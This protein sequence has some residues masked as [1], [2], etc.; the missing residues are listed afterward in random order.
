MK[1]YNDILEEQFNLQYYLNMSVKDYDENDVG[2]NRWLYSR[3]VD[4]KKKENEALKGKQP[5]G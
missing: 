3:L 5:N 4:Q 2:D 1:N